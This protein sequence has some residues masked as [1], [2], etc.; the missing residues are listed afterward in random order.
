MWDNT[1]IGSPWL[2]LMRNSLNT[3]IWSF[4]HPDFLVVSATHGSAHLALYDETVWD[5]YQI[6]KLAG[7]KFKINTL[8]ET[9]AAASKDAANYED[10]AGIFFPRGQFDSRA[11]ATRRRVYGVS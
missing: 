5:K 7:E 2:N 8:I 1:D 11:N 4:K 10:P 6:T 3:Q 9:K